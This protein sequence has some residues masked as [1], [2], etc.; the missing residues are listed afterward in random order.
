MRLAI[1]GVGVLF[2]VAAALGDGPAPSSRKGVALSELAWPDA[3]VWLTP[4]TVVVLPLGAGALE[5]GQHMKLDSDERLARHLVSRVMAASAVVVA[6]ALNYH[7]YP[8]YADYPGSTS[9]TDTSARD[10]T[11][12]A[13]RSLARSGPRRFYVLNTSPST[14]GPLSAAAKVLADAGI[15]LGYTDPAYWLKQTPVLKQAPIAVSHADEVATSMMLFLDPA[16]VDM[17]KATREYAPGRGALTRNDGGRGVVSKSGTLGD[18]TLAT[19]QKG[20]ALVGA[21]LAGIV[22]DI[23]NVRSARLPDARTAA[24]PAPVPT[25]APRPAERQ[26]ERMVTGCT[27]SEDRA[28]RA[29]G[30][31]LTYL[32]TQQDALHLSLLFSKNGDIRHPDGSIERGQEVILANR[33]QLFAQKEYTNSRYPVQLTDVRCLGPT[34]AIADGKW[35]LRLQ[36]TPQSMPGRVV[37]ATPYNSGWCTLVLLKNEGNNWSIDAWRY[38]I[39]PPPGADQ[40][41]LLAK[42]G[43]TG[44]EGG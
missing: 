36:N 32:W 11:V 19:A 39:N 31:R 25:P 10:I 7:F 8:A 22:A 40:P 2:A 12:D 5:Q 13:V 9:L 18:A 27:A 6:P 16:S 24:P 15:L 35:E 43:L 37:P 23:D 14:L 4:A 17:T 34:V 30:D 38:T 21:L 26:E 1:A 41:V 3:E 20:E 42:P 29:I 44:R 28:I 33:L